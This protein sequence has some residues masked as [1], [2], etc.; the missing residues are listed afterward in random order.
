MP[1]KL[2]TSVLLAT[3]SGPRT[4]ARRALLPTR[5]EGINI[6]HKSQPYILARMLPLP[7]IRLWLSLGYFRNLVTLSPPAL[8]WMDT[9]E[10]IGF[11]P[12]IYVDV[13]RHVELKRRMIA[14]IVAS[15]LEATIAIS[16]SLCCGNARHAARRPQWRPRSLS[17]TQRVE[18]NASVAVQKN[19][20]SSLHSIV[21]V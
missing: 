5:N 15:L 4:E 20:I 21:N 18:A 2:A 8:L 11:S 14:A 10:M 3:G 9:L 17:N 1:V 12:H 19:C 7:L 13:S 6:A 16:S